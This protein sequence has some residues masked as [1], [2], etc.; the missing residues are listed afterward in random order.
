MEHTLFNSVLIRPFNFFKGFYNFCLNR[1]IHFF[2]PLLISSITASLLLD[3]LLLILKIKTS[4]QKSSSQ[5]NISF[6]AILLITVN[7]SI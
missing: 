5:S 7:G 4:F 6:F 1:I 2:K 3:K